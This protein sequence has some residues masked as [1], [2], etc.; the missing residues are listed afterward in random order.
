MHST[1]AGLLTFIG[2]PLSFPFAGRL[3]LSV[4]EAFARV[5][6]LCRAPQQNQR[7]H[8]SDKPSPKD[9]DPII[10][11]T[12]L[13]ANVATPLSKLF[14]TMQ[15]ESYEA[16]RALLR[17]SLAGCEPEVTS[18]TRFLA[19]NH[20]KLELRHNWQ[21]MIGSRMNE[22]FCS[23]T[24]MDL[25]REF[26]EWASRFGF[27][28]EVRDALERKRFFEAAQT[29]GHVRMQFNRPYAGDG[30]AVYFSLGDDRLALHWADDADGFSSF[31]YNTTAAHA[32][33]M[34]DTFMRMWKP[35]E[36][37]I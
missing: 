6:S 30:I 25:V 31:I 17:D 7:S 34:M 21:G 35:P 16:A 20:P 24:L 37:D 19:A 13:P 36:P 22:C 27:E 33:E 8:W 5:E 10:A 23:F 18:V 14:A 4:R 26:G 12:V 32:V 3:G 29:Y 1:I 2:H 15:D 11:G 28:T 9:D